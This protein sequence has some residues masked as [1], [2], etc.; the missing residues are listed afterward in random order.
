MKRDAILS[1]A[2]SGKLNRL[3]ESIAKYDDGIGLANTVMSI[4]DDNGVG[5]AATEGKLNVLEYLIEELGLD[6]N[7]KDDGKGI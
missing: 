6:V 4:K 3:N 2:T 5:V 7:M 1:A